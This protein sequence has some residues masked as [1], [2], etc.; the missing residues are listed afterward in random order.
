MNRP[1]LTNSA[2]STVPVH[3]A[4]DIAL[5]PA[6]RGD[7]DI[8]PITDS[9]W[10]VRDNRLPEHDALCV[11]GVIEKNDTGSFEALKVGQGFIRSTFDSFEAATAHFAGS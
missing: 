8:Q 11:L 2:P 7:L 6:G 4:P 1:L 5:Q 3:E 10:R 9:V